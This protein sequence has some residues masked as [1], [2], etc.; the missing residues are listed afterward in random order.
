MA[1]LSFQPFPG[2]LFLFVEGLFHVD[3]KEHLHY[4]TSQVA[5]EYFL[6]RETTRSSLLFAPRKAGELNP[7]ARTSL[8][9]VC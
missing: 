3:Q 8:K 5:H 6:L 9:N 7:Q 4:Q 2:V 1:F